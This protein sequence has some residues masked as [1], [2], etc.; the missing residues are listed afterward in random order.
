MLAHYYNRKLYAAVC[1]WTKTRRYRHPLSVVGVVVVFV[2]VVVVGVV[3][4][5][6]VVVVD[7]GGVCFSSLQFDG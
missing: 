6:V 5:V 4:V 7:A 2:V 1:D 3:D